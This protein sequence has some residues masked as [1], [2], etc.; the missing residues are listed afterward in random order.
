MAELRLK[1]RESGSRSSSLHGIRH[2]RG[3][4][5]GWG[6]GGG[7]GVERD[8]ALIP[9]APRAGPKEGSRACEV[10][11]LTISRFDVVIYCGLGLLPS[12]FL[13]WSCEL[14]V[15]Q[16]ASHGKTGVLGGD[17]HIPPRTPSSRE[18]KSRVSRL[19]QASTRVMFGPRVSFK[20]SIWG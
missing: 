4:C 19:H 6:G 5:G 2:G 10:A 14:R 11:Y 15:L 1:L 18:P 8:R 13:A 3:V 17:V 9:S 20:M 7:G 12:T 16:Q